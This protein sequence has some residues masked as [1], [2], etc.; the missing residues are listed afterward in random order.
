MKRRHGFVMVLLSMAGEAALASAG[1]CEKAFQKVMDAQA[2]PDRAAAV[3]YFEN[4]RPTCGNDALYLSRLASFHLEA[5]RVREA[6]AAIDR[7]LALHPNHREL[8][9]GKGSMDLQRGD[10]V[11]ARSTAEK[12][13]RADS[14]WYGGHYL[15]QRVLMDAGQFQESIGHGVRAIELSRGALT[16]LYLNVGVASYHAGKLEDCVRYVRMAIQKEP[17]VLSRPWGI[18]EAIYALDRLERRAEALSLAKQRK[19]ADPNW[20]SDPVLVRA[21]KVMGVVQ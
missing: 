13:V 8:L 16:V 7:G 21:L 15:M 4:E 14:G 11:A 1:H 2:F 9:F 12:L 6:A 17:A 19:Q 3:R 20:Q 10:L 18:N 5:G